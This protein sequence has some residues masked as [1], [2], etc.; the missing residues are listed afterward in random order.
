[1]RV[2]RLRY[3]AAILTLLFASLSDAATAPS[4]AHLGHLSSIASHHRASVSNSNGGFVVLR[5]HIDK[6]RRS[7]RGVAAPIFPGRLCG[8]GV[9]LSATSLTNSP[10]DRCCQDCNCSHC[11]GACSHLKGCAASCAHGGV[12][13]SAF[14]LRA[15]QPSHEFVVCQQ[16]ADGREPPPELKPPQA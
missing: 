13:T 2:L 6:R 8:R 5:V 15:P 9:H 14:V 4:T 10:F 11:A 3:I 1:M 7:H 12:I 16:T